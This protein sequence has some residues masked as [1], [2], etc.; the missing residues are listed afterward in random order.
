MTK[1]RIEGQ[2]FIALTF[3]DGP[4]ITTTVEVLEKLKKY[5]EVATFFL[6][7]DHITGETEGVV[8]AA[9]SM[10]CEL[11][12]HSKT[13]GV[14]SEMTRDEILREMEYTTRRIKEVIGVNPKFF[15]PPYIAFNDLMYEVI[16]LPFICGVGAEDWEPSVSSKERAHRIL[17]QACDGGIILLHDMEG[18]VQ[19]VEALDIIIP[20]LRKRGY[21]LVTV[22]QL[23]EIK[24]VVPDK[25]NKIIYTNVLQTK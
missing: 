4:N 23:F 13:H 5:G 7:G 21:Q 9:Y 22:S 2:G 12:H 25:T 24:Q 17:E 15:R 11:A 8:R 3:D 20:E 6:V 16:D 18:N 14:M 10:G 1:K 19:T